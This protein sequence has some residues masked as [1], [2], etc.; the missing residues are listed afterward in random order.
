MSALH[1]LVG[2]MA[3]LTNADADGRILLDPAAGTL[4][5][6]LLNAAA[7]FSKVSFSCSAM[8]ALNTLH[9]VQISDR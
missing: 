8:T 3:S 1:A 5:F 7:H 6:L 9:L 2:F 4:K